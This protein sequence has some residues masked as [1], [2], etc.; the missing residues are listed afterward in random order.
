MKKQVLV[1]YFVIIL[2]GIGPVGLFSQC[3]TGVLW[4][5]GATPVC[6]GSPNILVSGQYAGEYSTVNLTAGTPYIFSSSIGTDF[7]TVATNVPAAVAS[8]TGSVAYT[9]AVTGL[10]RIYIHTNPACG[11]QAAS[12]NILVSCGVPP[13]DNPCTATPLPVT[14]TCSYATYTNASATNTA[15]VPLP[16][17][18]G[19]AGG[20]VWFTVTVP[21]SGQLNFDTQTGIMLDGGMAVYSGTCGS[22]SLVA[23]DDN[24]SPNGAMPAL[25]LTGLTPGA[26]LWIRV[27]E[28]GNNNN[29]SFGI[30]VVNPNP[31]P[32]PGDCPNAINVCSN[33]SLSI[34]PSG[35][36]NIVEFGTGSVSNPSVNPNCCNQGCLITGEVHSTWLRVTIQT[37]GTFQCSFGSPASG[38][39]CYDWS[40]WGPYNASTCTNI[41]SNSLTPLRCNWN[42]TC[43]GFT[44]I[45]APLPPGGIANNFEAPFAVI[46]G[47]QYIFCFSNYSSQT[48]TIPVNFF[49]TATIGCGP[50]PI[51]L[52]SFFCSQKG[53]KMSLEWITSSETNNNYFVV[54]RSPDGVNF[55]DIGTKPG[56]GNSNAAMKYNFTD[57][58]PLPGP[59]YYRLKQVDFD[60]KTE[61][62][63]TSVC[64][65][66]PGQESEVNIYNMTGQI[67]QS[68]RTA[69][70]M[71]DINGLTL[72]VGM[73]ILEIIHGNEKTYQTHFHG[74]GGAHWYG[75]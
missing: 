41:A 65:F 12:R 40:M 32:N 5:S 54:E 72:P 35:P 18:A 9:P 28:N 37:S 46:A 30:C 24:S 63:Q 22:L 44:G 56:S 6:N 4:Q 42:G 8:G 14:V 73:Y 66:T 69:D 33:T 67:I 3:L 38:F 57:H 26:T 55:E 50:L 71:V 27:W 51:E 20:D 48:A 59:N 19:Y 21:A 10:Y 17:C 36:G 43:D 31:P 68:I 52:L 62:F 39:V 64:D 47:Q 29:G 15:G 23:C 74:D 11:T 75:E 16:L 25:N 1:H 60:G 45:A 61:T 53:T 2:L 49:G 58:H 7:L 70:Y 34:S 13:N